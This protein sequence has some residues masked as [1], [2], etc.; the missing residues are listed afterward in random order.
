M[1]SISFTRGIAVTLLLS[2]IVGCGQKGPLIV[3]QPAPI[4]EPENED[5]K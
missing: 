4:Q 3:E 5:T 2:I 1:K